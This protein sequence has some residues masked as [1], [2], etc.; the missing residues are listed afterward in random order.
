MQTGFAPLIVVAIV[1]VLAIG[2]GVYYANKKSEDKIETENE[3][4]IEAEVN[5]GARTEISLGQASR[6]TLR[7]LFKV[8][9]D[10][11]CTVSGPQANGETS[12]TV[13]I[14]AEGDIRGDFVTEA[15]SGADVDSHMIIQ[16]DTAHVWNGTEGVAMSTSQLSANASA[17][18]EVRFSVDVNSQVDYTCSE[19][20]RDESKFNL[21]PNVTFVDIGA[22]IENNIPINIDLETSLEGKLY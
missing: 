3:A 19:W 17:Q 18:A 1:A 6:G 8:G 13:F 20:S 2:G 16:D 10:V 5:V 14:S 12:G 9:R 4:N 21:P 15:S 11:T 22:M 7:G